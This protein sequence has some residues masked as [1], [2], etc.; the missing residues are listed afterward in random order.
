MKKNIVGVLAISSL[1][2]V[3]CLFDSEEESSGNTEK[4]VYSE[5]PSTINSTGSQDFELDEESGTYLIL[6]QWEAESCDSTGAF[7]KEVELDSNV[8][9]YE[10]KDGKLLLWGEHSCFADELTGSGTI[11]Q[12]SWTL[13]KGSK[14]VAIPGGAKFPEYCEGEEA[15][16]Y[17]G[18]VTLK[19]SNSKLSY[20]SSYETCWAEEELEWEQERIEM[21]YSENKNVEAIGCNQLKFT[22]K[23]GKVYTETMVSLEFENYTRVS[24]ISYNDKTCEKALPSYSNAL[25]EQIC[26]EAYQ[27]WESDENAY[28]DFYYYGYLPENEYEKANDEFQKCLV[29]IGLEDEDQITTYD[30]KLK[31]LNKPQASENT[32]RKAPWKM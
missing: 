6:S 10:V 21:E 9:H 28:G 26:K 32:Q 19:F 7:V 15:D 14:E 29:A 27:A 20:V 8:N 17:S 5:S 1:A 13:S 2:L 22:K 4:I 23:D 11:L 18:E 24:N 12:G 25:N 16:V 30:R 3:G 31:R